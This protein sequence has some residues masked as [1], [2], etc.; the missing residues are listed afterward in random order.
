[1]AAAHLGFMGLAVGAEQVVLKGMLGGTRST[2]RSGLLDRLAFAAYLKLTYCTHRNS[3]RHLAVRVRVEAAVWHQRA[4]FAFS[5]FPASQMGL[6]SCASVPDAP[7]RSSGRVHTSCVQLPQK[8]V[9]SSLQE[10]SGLP[11]LT[12]GGTRHLLQYQVLNSIA[13]Q[14]SVRADHASP[15]HACKGGT[16]ASELCRSYLSAVSNY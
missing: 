11:A 1:M 10:T 2:R 9:T 8:L 7:P 6:P 13:E 14:E 16:H 4:A 12:A 3:R 5:P 15:V